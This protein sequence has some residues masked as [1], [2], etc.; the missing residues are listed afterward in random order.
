MGKRRRLFA[1]AAL[2]SAILLALTFAL[3][4]AAFAVNPWD[5][6]LSVTTVTEVHCFQVTIPWYV[7]LAVV[8][9]VVLVLVWIFRKNSRKHK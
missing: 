9:M 7:A 4:L 2:V 3:W 6:H 5:H 1:A 8:C